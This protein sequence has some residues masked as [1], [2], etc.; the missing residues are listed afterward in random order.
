M[1]SLP[2]LNVDFR[3]RAPALSARPSSGVAV[4]HLTRRR[5]ETRALSQPRRPE[6]GTASGTGSGRKPRGPSARRPYFSSV[7]SSLRAD[8]CQTVQFVRIRLRLRSPSINL[9]LPTSKCGVDRVTS[10]ANS[11]RHSRACG[12]PRPFLHKRRSAI[13]GPY[14]MRVRTLGALVAGRHIMYVWRGVALPPACPSAAAAAPLWRL[15]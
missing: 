3:P 6:R 9:E 1:P 12:L 4:V 11:S 2:A 13:W 15:K 7:L 10:Y 5:L 8:M 14:H